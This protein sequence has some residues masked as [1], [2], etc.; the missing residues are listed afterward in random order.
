MSSKRPATWATASAAG[1]PGV[2]TLRADGTVEVVETIELSSYGIDIRRG[3]YRDIPTALVN[4]DGSRLRLDTATQ[5]EVRFYH[6]NERHHTVALA[7]APFELPQRLHHVMVETVERAMTQWPSLI[8]SL[9]FTDAQRG[10]LLAAIPASA[11]P[12]KLRR[13][14]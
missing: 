13:E 1:E 5:L 14:R 12:S 9:P 3:I 4:A 8:E 10:K 2:L 6:C 11:P 7:R